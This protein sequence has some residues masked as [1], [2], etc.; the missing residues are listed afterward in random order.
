[1][2]ADVER[3]E[4]DDV[5]LRSRPGYPPDVCLRLP[6]TTWAGPGGFDS[7]ASLTHRRETQQARPR[8]SR[9]LQDRSWL[10]LLGKLV[11]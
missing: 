7:P 8:R 10:C 11:P 6:R 5:L 2:V 3:T 9:A 4:L 1:M